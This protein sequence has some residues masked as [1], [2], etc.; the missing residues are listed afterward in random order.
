MSFTSD[1]RA[2][3]IKNRLYLRLSGVMTD[4]DAVSVADR[5]MAEI[6][7]LTPGFAVIND[8]SNLKPASQA[9]TE[10]LRR[11][12]EAS[13]K[14]GSRR[15]IRVVGEQ[16]ITEMQWNR[17]LKPSHGKAAEVAATVEQAERM[18]DSKN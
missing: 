9:A 5:I 8:I 11:A 12:Q 13:V 7:K 3:I 14:S 15:V 16:V 6:G 2:N 17:T 4:Q 1:I 10:H 18:L